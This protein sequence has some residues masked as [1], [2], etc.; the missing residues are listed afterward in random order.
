MDYKELII[1]MINQISD[2]DVLQK[3]YHYTL[4]K[5]RREQEKKDTQ[6]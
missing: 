5:Y 1:D 3:I 4:I 2:S 6:K